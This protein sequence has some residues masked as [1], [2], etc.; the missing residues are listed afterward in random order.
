MQDAEGD[1]RAFCVALEALGG[2]SRTGDGVDWYD[3]A[4]N[5]AEISDSWEE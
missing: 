2:P 5:V 4:I 3:P 1:Y